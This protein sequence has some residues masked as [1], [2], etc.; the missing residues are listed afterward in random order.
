VIVT[1]AVVNAVDVAAALEADV[2][3]GV[4][5]PGPHAASSSEIAARRLIDRLNSIG[6]PLPPHEPTRRPQDVR[7]HIVRLGTVNSGLFTVGKVE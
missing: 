6:I 7:E 3:D 4:A 2:G 5:V 1:G